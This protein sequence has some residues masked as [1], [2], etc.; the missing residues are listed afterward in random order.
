MNK[1]LQNKVALITGGASGIGAAHVRLFSDAGAKVL[2]C[3][4]QEELGCRV[5][6]DVKRKSG[7]AEFFR[8]DVTDESNWKKAVAEAV[9]RFGSLTTL[10]N[11]AGI[12]I[13]GGV[14]S[15]SNEGWNRVVAVNQTGVWLGMKTAMPELLKSGNAAI[16]NI[17]SLYGLVGSPEGIAYHAS[18]AAVRAMS[19][20]AAVEYARRGLRVN[21]VYPGVI[22]TPILGEVPDYMMKAL[23]EALPMGR[24]GIPED[25]AYASLYLCSDEAQFVTGA[26][27]CVDG[28]AYAI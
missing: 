11:N 8:L 27:L 1:R 15:E 21:T 20:A 7:E 16:V 3:D 14:E 23:E 22:K 13:P 17:S 10:I 4:V 24:I 6:D 12:F 5:V 25:I 26:D 19:K 28:G 2:V 9:G 18:K